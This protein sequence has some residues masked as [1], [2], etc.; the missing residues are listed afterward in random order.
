MISDPNTYD[1][2]NGES[3]VKPA[4][5]TAWLTSTPSKDGDGHAGVTSIVKVLG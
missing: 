5:S 4:C 3:A 1:M 2:P